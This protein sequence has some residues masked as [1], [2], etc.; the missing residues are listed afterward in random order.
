[1]RRRYFI[2]LLAAVLLLGL[3][4][5]C[6]GNG[7][8]DG[9]ATEEPV[10]ASTKLDKPPNEKQIL[11]D[12]NHHKDLAQ[13]GV[14]IF[15]DCEI[16]KRQSNPERKEDIVY[17]K[18]TAET[19]FLRAERQYKLLY[20][21]YDEGGWIL[22]T[23]APEREDEWTEDYLAADGKPIL[24]SIIWLNGSYS[25]SR[26]AGP[27]LISV[28]SSG[29]WG[30]IDRA[31]GKEV[32]PCRFEYNNEMDFSK[33]TDGGYVAAVKYGP[34]ECYL[35]DRELNRLSERYDSIEYGGS[36]KRDD[37]TKIR[38]FSCVREGRI[39]FLAE[40][41]AVVCVLP[42]D[43]PVDSPDRPKFIEDLCVVQNTAGLYGC[44]DIKGNIVIPFQYD[45]LDD[46]MDGAA[47][48]EKG[49]K[50]AAIDKSGKE[51][52]PFTY[53]SYIDVGI[54][55]GDTPLPAW[56]SSYTKVR[57]LA[58]GSGLFIVSQRNVTQA[59]PNDYSGEEIL[60]GLAD[61][62]GNFVIPLGLYKDI[63]SNG[64]GLFKAVS[65]NSFCLYDWNG[66]RR[67]PD[68]STNGDH[69]PSDAVVTINDR[70]GI[71]PKLLSEA[72]LEQFKKGD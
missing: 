13:S 11:S 39:S 36:L 17:C 2:A 31:T 61:A 41:G 23:V 69:L 59:N 5:G 67:T 45:Y 47:V 57:L 27:E 51:L 49:G 53:N 4:A 9:T 28:K 56:A 63:W 37:G 21:F 46:F 22:D 55:L 15:T 10:K 8:G 6:G 3:L 7:A 26:F 30:Y 50:C 40:L 14:S 12:V 1:M 33:T 66:N 60:F 70:Q 71:L 44:V 34:N 38:L 29:K 24:E 65:E 25:D 35:V 52:I 19:S 68:F 58:K 62:D 48:A 54:A 42:D 16:I 64:T 72:E 32:I 43:V 18:L 20:N